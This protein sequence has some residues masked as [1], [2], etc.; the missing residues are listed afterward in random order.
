LWPSP[1]H[2]LTSNTRMLTG[3]LSQ[4]S[5]QLSRRQNNTDSRAS[6]HMLGWL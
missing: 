2:A 5:N 1:N 6:G 4:I 3:W